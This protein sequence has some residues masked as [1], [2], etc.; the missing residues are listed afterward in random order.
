MRI[1]RPQA[2]WHRLLV[3]ALLDRHDCGIPTKRN[4]V[5]EGNGSPSSTAALYDMLIFV[6]GSGNSSYEGFIAR[7][8]HRTDHG[9]SLKAEY[10]WAKALS[11]SSVTPSAQI[12]SCRLCDKGQATFDVRYRVVTSAVWEFPFTKTRS[13]VSLPVVPPLPSA[14]TGGS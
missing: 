11:E 7:Y 5:A 6:N 14:L 8:Q 3:L 2:Q 9:L 1:S 13:F 12:A 4:I 10:T